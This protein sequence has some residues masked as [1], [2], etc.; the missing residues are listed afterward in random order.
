MPKLTQNQTQH[1]PLDWT[2]CDTPIAA[3]AKSNPGPN[4]LKNL[5]INLL[6]IYSKIFFDEK[7]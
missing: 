6:L 1:Q 4:F 7:F 2:K 5:I 3:P